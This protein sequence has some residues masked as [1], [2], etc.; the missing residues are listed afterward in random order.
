MSK[1][2]GG[3]Y[4]WRTRKPS[5]FLG[6]SLKW[7]L[8]GAALLC[9]ALLIL[10]EGWWAAAP[11]LLVLFSGRHNAYAGL[12]NS[13]YF[14]EQQHIVGSSTWGSRAKPWSDLDPKV[15]RIPLPN[16]ITHKGGVAKAL[17]LKGRWTLE[18]LETLLIW[19]TFTVYNAQKQ[20]PWNLRRIP[21][22]KAD[23][24]RMA[25]EK[26]GIGVNLGRVAV[27]WALM[28][29]IVAGATWAGWEAW[30]VN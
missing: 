19:L 17:G 9:S 2:S 27:R 8:A 15:Y 5:S 1:P 23:A 11:W 7:L 3:L 13:F 28:L 16:F 12:T 6:L 20:P 4:L 21:P 14:R 22:R 30:I 26:R 10:G 25:R 24:Q 29:V 18:T